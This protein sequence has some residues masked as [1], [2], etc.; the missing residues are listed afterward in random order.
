MASES[1]DI[2]DFVYRWSF[3]FAVLTTVLLVL[4]IVALIVKNPTILRDCASE[5]CL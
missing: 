2:A 3:R 1:Q 4:V 5:L